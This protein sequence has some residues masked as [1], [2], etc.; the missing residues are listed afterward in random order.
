MLA[1]AS[2]DCEDDAISLANDTRYGLAAGVW[3]SDRKRAERVAK[4]IQ[5]GTVYINHYR[6]VDPGS[7]IGG[8]KKSGYGRELGPDAVRAFFTNQI[9]M[10][11]DG[12]LYRPVPGLAFIL[13]GDKPCP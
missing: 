6:S 8:Y 3:T 2:F 5:A 12:A 13:F 4:Q 11:R 7:P 1:V 9:G 10:A